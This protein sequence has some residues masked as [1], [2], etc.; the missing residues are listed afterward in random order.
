MENKKIIEE[1]NKKIDELIKKNKL[2]EDSLNKISIDFEDLNDKSYELTVGEIQNRDE[3]IQYI[4]NEY[5]QR[6]NLFNEEQKIFS[7]LFHQLGE[8]VSFINNNLHSNK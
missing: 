4:Q 2:L 7:S 5:E 6:R 1:K 3:I 8:Y